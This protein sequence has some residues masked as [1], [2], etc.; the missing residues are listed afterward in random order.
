M[1]STFFNLEIRSGLRAPMTWIFLFLFALLTFFA[2][3]SDNVTIGASFGNIYK[4]APYVIQTWY[5]VFSVLSLLLLTAYLNTA[6]IRDFEYKTA[7]IVFSTPI[8][9]ANYYFGHFLGALLISIIPLLGIS[10]GL[11]I[12]VAI[13]SFTEWLDPERFGPFEIMG[14]INSLIT[15]VIPNTIFAGGILFT[16]A[17]LTRST[18]YSFI[19]AMVLLAGYIIAGNLIGNIDNE[20]L[21]AMLDP[22]GFRALSTVSKY[23]TVDDKNTSSVSILNGMML[24]NRLIWMSVGIAV[25]LF[26]Y[27]R[28]SFAERR[29]KG[30]K[31]EE[32]IDAYQIKQLEHMPKVATTFG[33]NTTISQYISQLKSNFL[34]VVK[35]APFI[36]LAFIGLI[37]MVSGLASST[38]A[39]GTHN[40]PVTYEMVEIIRGT[41]YLFVTAI[42]AYYS[43][44]LVWQERRVK[45]NE[46]YDA[47]PTLN[48]T[49]FL[50]KFKT[51][52]G[53]VFLLNALAIIAGVLFQ[54]IAGYGRFELG[55]YIRELLIIDLLAFTFIAALFLL[56]HALSP[57]MY[58][59]FFLC[60]VI[61]VVNTFAWSALRISTNM[62]AFGATPGYTISEFYGY[63]P[64][65]SGLFWFNT[66]WGIFSAILAVAAVCFWPRGVEK[67]FAKRL[68]IAALE[69]RRYR[70]A[71]LSAIVLFILCGAWVYYNTLVVNAYDGGKEREKQTVRYEKEYKKFDGKKQ[72]RIYDVKYDIKIFPKE[73][74]IEANGILQLRNPY[75]EPLD[76][77]LVAVPNDPEF[78]MTS[79]R[80]KLLK[81]DD[82]VKFAIYQIDP[83]LLPFDSME[84]SFN[85]DY[86]AEGF[87]NELTV[88][89][90]MTNG[91][92]F[93]SPGIAPRF[94]YQ[95]SRELSSKNLRKKYGLPE[96]DPFPI[97]SQQDTFNRRNSYIAND[98]DWVNVETII[99]TSDDQIAIGPGSLR[100]QWT[101][102]GRNYYQY[103]L[104]HKSL[105]FYSFMSAD[106]EVAKEK[107]NG[108][109]FEVY[110][111]KEHDANV[112]RMLKSM[113]KSVEYFTENF[114]PYYHKQCRIIEFPRIAS[115]AQAFPGTMPYSES[116]GFIEDYREEEDDID[117]VYYVVAHEMGHQWWAHQECGA[118]MQGGVFL[119]E[120]LAQYSALMVM[121]E[122]Y[123]RDI[124]RKFLEYEAD[125]YLRGRGRERRKEQPLGKCENQGYI[126]YRKGSVVMYYLKEMIGE[127]NVNKA[128]RVFLDK[129][130]YAEPPYPVSIDLI[131]EF[132]KVTPDSLKYIIDDLF[133]DIT[134]FENRTE[135]A[136][137]KE[138]DNGQFEVTLEVSCRKLKADDLGKET[139]VA[140]NDWI[141]IGAFA[142]P[143]GNKKY[144]KTLYRKRVKIDK[145]KNTFTFT[146][147]EKPD[148]AGIDPFRLLIDRNPEDNVRDL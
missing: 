55:V 138:L 4:N 26:G 82:K 145:E 57:N 47:M 116:I 108:I 27:F 45:V 132:E 33:W 61:L 120:T 22:F 6:A 87:E 3:V 49:D 12:G 35:S 106:Y 1:F 54:S 135:S 70:G 42:V 52:V 142:K 88:E 122:E 136:E 10:L 56:I 119:V 18:L 13:N 144:G 95:T 8:Q 75:D 112:G 101:E 141:D 40:F 90:V 74:A 20:W 127:E 23:W 124:M 2:T 34:G 129:F 130:K 89:E 131:D 147:D 111:Q 123:G 118:E 113:R 148:Q 117:M 19:S 68:S 146:V 92:F 53:I 63:R 58:L 125:I 139:A 121:E 77:L 109:D 37:N 11:W 21:G 51:I 114:G 140:I 143:E 17:A 79:D 93:S 65:A 64:Y 69:W 133:W 104:D 32:E 31:K 99:S 98:A 84:L 29:K 5:G 15:L 16:I 24:L 94:G 14:H 80:I 30:K 78:A 137:Y 41:Y 48:W 39:Y 59:G 100:K 50:A 81:M 9:K 105:N 62:V 72:P 38:Q 73:R 66:Y 103:Q 128:L 46:I 126:H 44:Y 7:Q 96:K 28:F 110:Y 102:G 91:T 107:W 134:L 115:F 43:G 86:T 67:S 36:L 60:I 85:S 71:G 97:L 83:P 76:S 25:L